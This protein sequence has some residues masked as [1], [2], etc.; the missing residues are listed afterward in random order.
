MLDQIAGWAAPAATMVAAVMTASNLG[1]RVTGWG[2]IV[3]TV[4][5]LA[6]CAVALTSGQSNLLWTNGLLV[7]VN[8]LGVWRWLGRQARYDE[9]AAA[10][11]EASR[12]PSRSTLTPLS[13]MAGANVIGRNGI[14]LGQVVDAMIRCED[15]AI[16]YLVISD[17]GLGGVGETLYALDATEAELRADGVGVRLDATA[18]R[19]REPLN[20][21]GWPSALSPAHLGAPGSP[22]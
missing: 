19:R 14:V 5:S 1:A 17:G 11:A 7:A 18:L 8:L 12:A 2:F 22:C 20:K 3:F 10:A 4:G 13:G 6:W 15:G 16:A 9:G 21:T